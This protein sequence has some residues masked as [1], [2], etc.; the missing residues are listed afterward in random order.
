MRI[1]SSARIVL[2]A[3]AGVILA[4]I[5]TPL[6]IVLINSFN[7]SSNLPTSRSMRVIMAA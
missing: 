7:K 1:S 6:A 2:G 3:I 4:L 5:Y